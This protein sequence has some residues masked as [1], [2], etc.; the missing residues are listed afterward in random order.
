[1][2]KKILET[3]AEELKTDIYYRDY[4]G[5]G[6]VPHIFNTALVYESTDDC[7][8]LI[9]VTDPTQFPSSCKKNTVKDHITANSVN[10]GT[11]RKINWQHFNDEYFTVADIETTGL[12]PDY[13]AKIIEIGAVKIRADGTV[14]D[15]FSSFINPNMKLPK[16]IKELTNITQEQVDSAPTLHE[17]LTSFWEFFRGS[18]IVFHNADFDWNRFLIPNFKRVGIVVPDNYPCIDTLRVY[19]DMCPDVKRHG[20]ADL[21]EMYR[22]PIE[23]HHRAIHDARMTAKAFARM[24]A[25]CK[26]KFEHLP[27]TKWVRAKKETHNIEVRRVSFWGAY[28]KKSGNPI[29]ERQYVDFSIDG[30]KS[31]A[32]FEILENTW[33]IQN[34]QI[35]FDVSELQDAVLKFLELTSVEELKKFRN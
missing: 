3:I 10:L 27:K 20:L 29:K 21:C 22:I 28:K 13:G 18:T 35:T 12:S 16:K 14:V 6:N 17:V 2:Q 30:K 11:I 34:C 31:S 5:L 24:R 4:K 25:D 9:V 26:G 19:K 7:G 15:E 23:N 32:F 1:M 8:R 33:V